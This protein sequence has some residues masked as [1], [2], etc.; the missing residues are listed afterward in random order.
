M[1]NS[2]KLSDLYVCTCLCHE[3][4]VHML[5]AIP[6]CNNTYCP[7]C[8][9]M[10]ACWNE[11]YCPSCEDMIAYNEY[12]EYAEHVCDCFKLLFNISVD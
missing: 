1:S 7:S 5:H 2:I 10:I 4:G 6:C 3:E 9:D 8:E 12:P 11:A